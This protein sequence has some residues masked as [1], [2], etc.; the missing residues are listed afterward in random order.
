MYSRDTGRGTSREG[1]ES[2]PR[3]SR[4]RRRQVREDGVREPTLEIRKRLDTWI[5]I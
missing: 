5:S 2:F 3:G 4:V 1:G